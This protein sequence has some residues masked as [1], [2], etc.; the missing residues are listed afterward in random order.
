MLPPLPRRSGWAYFSLISPSRVSLPRKGHRV[1]LHIVLFEACSAFTRVAACTLAR[2]PIR[3]P[4]SEGF[5]H[6]VAS[7]L[8]RLLPAGANRRVG[9][10]PTGKRRLVTAHTRCGRP[11]HKQNAARAGAL[12][13]RR[14]EA[15]AKRFWRRR[16]PGQNKPSGLAVTTAVRRSQRITLLH[17]LT[18]AEHVYADQNGRHGAD[19]PT[20]TIATRQP[21]QQR[22]DRGTGQRTD[23]AE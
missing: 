14:R 21:E 1:G 22:E 19:H 8:I 13:R 4:L 2:S 3:D 16:R 23:L 10:A 11:T 5:R 20:S 6:F 15:V 9:L 18:L 7:M 12:T 17:R